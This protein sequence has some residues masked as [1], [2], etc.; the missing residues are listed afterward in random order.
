VPTRGTATPSS[1]RDSASPGRVECVA[2][3]FAPALHWLTGNQRGAEAS[4]SRSPTLLSSPPVA[5]AKLAPQTGNP[6]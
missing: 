2:A 1:R 6:C 3:R 5:E 4:T